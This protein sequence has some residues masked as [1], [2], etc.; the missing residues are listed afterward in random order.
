MGG[1]KYPKTM[2]ATKSGPELK[3]SQHL[4]EELHWI[5]FTAF[6]LSA[7]YGQLPSRTADILVETYSLTGL[8]ARDESSGQPQ[9]LESGD[10]DQRKERHRESLIYI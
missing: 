4:E 2:G 9:Q 6:S 1:K 3:A 7:C 8:I 10:G 5:S